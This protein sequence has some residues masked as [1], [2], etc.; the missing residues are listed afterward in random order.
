M[1]YGTERIFAN[2]FAN[3]HR[4]DNHDNIR[5]KH[6]AKYGCQIFRLCLNKLGPI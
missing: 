6:G 3:R 4:N 2:T 1:L 5:Y